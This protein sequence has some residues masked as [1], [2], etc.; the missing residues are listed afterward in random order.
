MPVSALTEVTAPEVNGLG[1][2]PMHFDQY[3]WSVGELPLYADA[4]QRT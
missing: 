2:F 1:V 3:R 4:A